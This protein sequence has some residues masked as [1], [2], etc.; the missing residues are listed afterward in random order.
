ME[1]GDGKELIAEDIAFVIKDGDKI[2]LRSLEFKDISA[3]EGVD[4]SLIDTLNSTM[5]IK[6]KPLGVSQ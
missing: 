1:K 5:L 4:I 2:I 6:S 3:L